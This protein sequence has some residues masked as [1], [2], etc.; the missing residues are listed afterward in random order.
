MKTLIISALV[1]S[2]FIV[3][4]NSGVSKDQSPKSTDKQSVEGKSTA[5]AGASK[6]VSVN[7]IIN[8]YL[9]LKNALTNDNDQDAA[10]AGNNLV[11]AFAAFDSK[12]LTS[13]QA[14][15]Y[16]DIQ[17][18]A[19][20]H[21]EHIAANAGNIA[22]QREH[23]ENLSKD[24]YDL[25]KAFDAGQKLYFDHCPMYNNNKGANWISENKEIQNPYLGK[26]MST[27][28]TL[29]EEL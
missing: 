2:L 17:D 4:C 23:F 25:A 5:E 1:T 16:K 10:A 24:I 11:K 14:K 15:I 3:S 26:A 8:S 28:G 27:C 19:K 22:H 7:G 6:S 21:A 20:E 18:D 12:S 9:Q 29:K 13:E